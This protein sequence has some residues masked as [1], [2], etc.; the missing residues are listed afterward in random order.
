M[1]IK[2]AQCFG[3]CFFLLVGFG[4]ISI[5]AQ[6]NSLT[7][8]E[9]DKLISQA[10]AV[11]SS[12][13]KIFN[14]N[15][16]LLTEQ[17]AL[18]SPAQNEEYL[19]LQAYKLGI[20]GNFK[21]SIIAHKKVEHSKNINVRVRSLKTQLNLQFLAN[22]FAESNALVNK[23]LI[24]L[25]TLTNGSLRNDI[26]E[27]IAFYYNHIEE[28]NLALN[29]LK[30][31]DKEH[32]YNRDIC[33]QEEF[34]LLSLLGLKQITADDPTIFEH[35]NFCY[36]N[37]EFIMGN[38]LLLEQARYLNQEQKHAQAIEVLTAQKTQI[39]AN[40]F[41]P[42]YQM[43]FSQLSSAYLGLSQL[44]L[45][46][47]YGEKALAQVKDNDHSKWALQIYQI[48]ANIAKQQADFELAIDYLLR[49]EKIQ[50]TIN[51]IEQ[52]KAYARAQIDHTRFNKVQYKHKLVKEKIQ[53]EQKHNNA[54]SEMLSYINKFENARVLLAIQICG[55][56]LLGAGILY[57]RHL[58]IVENEKNRHDPLTK[59]FNRNRFI[60]LA[61]TT[62]YQHKKWQ[63]DL[64]LLVVNIDNFRGF[65][66]QHSY[67][68]GDQ[69]L[70]LIAQILHN[71]VRIDEHIARTGADEFSL[72]LPKFNVKQASQIAQNI[73]LEMAKVS[74]ELQLEDEEITVS[75]GISDAE[76]SEFSLK[77]LI[78]DSSKALRKAKADDGNTSCCFESSMT[79]REKYKI[80]D[81]GLKYFFE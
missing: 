13:S 78:A 58:Q 4:L 5:P 45:A 3:F 23:L 73:H 56:L 70:T 19:Y 24:E 69:L 66:Q 2:L 40:K 57:I 18:L 17:K 74:N 64:S 50:R 75:I 43:L 1:T 6:A 30:L 31:I 41:T 14:Q 8:T 68:K 33:Y 15:L 34:N 10:I 35:I 36:K 60:D 29:Y 55:I 72:L 81:N 67:N 46:K 47:E 48:L 49:Y 20:E 53:A 12:D 44:E 59:L 76:L 16:D 32:N 54:F 7:G 77:Y 11:R 61:A 25:P 22:N 51:S 52:Q 71:Y 80:D 63:M 26:L 62:V 37:N 38:S 39:L 42:H 9:I 28:F 21:Q 27:T 65:N 79:D